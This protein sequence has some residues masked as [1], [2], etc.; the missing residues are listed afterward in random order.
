MSQHLVRSLK[1]LTFLALLLCVKQS[2]YAEP[3]TQPSTTQAE[4]IPTVNL[5]PVN[6][7][8]RLVQQ[9]SLAEDNE[10]QWLQMINDANPEHREAIAYLLINMPDEDIKSLKPG[11]IADDVDLAYRARA[12]SAWASAIPKEIFFQEV[13]PYANMD[14]VR[15]DWRAEYFKRF[16]PLV[17]N[18]KSA[19]EAEQILNKQVFPMVKVKYHATK[20]LKPNQSPAESE[21]IGYASCTGLSIIL[22]DACR[23]CGVPARVAGTPLWSDKSGNHTWTEV[24]DHQWYYVGSAE[25]GPLNQTWFS[26]NAS[27]ADDSKSDNRIYAVSFEQSPLSFPLVWDARRCR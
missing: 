7:R 16:M 2:T 11:F 18:A 9:L 27:K 19:S 6:Y 14:E 26:E 25:P 5:V 23:A 17:K 24:W 12:A 4:L 1:Y 8:H 3:S 21:K 22:V 15:E 20:R 13:L 10:G